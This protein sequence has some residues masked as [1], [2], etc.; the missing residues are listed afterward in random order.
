[1]KM[2]FVESNFQ[3]RKTFII[4][5]LLLGAKDSTDVHTNESAER[6]WL[7]SKLIMM[8]SFAI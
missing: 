4:I 6:S 3:E 2:H 8:K 1:M 7:N 5:E